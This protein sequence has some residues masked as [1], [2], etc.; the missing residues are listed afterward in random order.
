M[1]L[2]GWKD[3]GAADESNTVAKQGRG[4]ACHSSGEVE[5]AVGASHI[6][7]SKDKQDDGLKQMA[8]LKDHLFFHRPVSSIVSEHERDIN[9]KAVFMDGSCPLAGHDAWLQPSE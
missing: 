8:R 4:Q 5:V 3:K 1:V 2:E 6:A 7:V 9:E